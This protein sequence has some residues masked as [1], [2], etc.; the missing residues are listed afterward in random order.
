MPHSFAV[1]IF[2]DL[3]DDKVHTTTLEKPKVRFERE[4]D[5]LIHLPETRFAASIRETRKISWDCLVSYQGSRYSCPHSYAG[6]R[7]WVRESKGAYLSDYGTL[8]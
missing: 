6:K 5:L 7:V 1:G 8:R 2:T 4:K 3:W